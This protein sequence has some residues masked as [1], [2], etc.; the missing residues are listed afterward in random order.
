MSI[1]SSSPPQTTCADTTRPS[2]QDLESHCLFCL[3]LP[4]PRLYLTNEESSLRAY[5]CCTPVFHLLSSFTSTCE[6]GHINSSFG[7]CLRSFYVPVI[8]CNEQRQHLKFILAHSLKICE[9][10]LAAGQ[11]WQQGSG[12]VTGSK[13]E[14]D[15]IFNNKDV[16]KRELLVR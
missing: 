4:F 16:A 15:H 2:L 5:I 9:S 3:P 11:T 14:R 8:K 12:T 7:Q 10:I 1:T 13:K 6:R